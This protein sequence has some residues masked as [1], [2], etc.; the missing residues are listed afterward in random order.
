MTLQ[1]LEVGAPPATQIY[2]ANPGEFCLGRLSSRFLGNQSVWRSAA[3]LAHS[4]LR[5]D[6]TGCSQQFL[7][8][9][10]LF[11]PTLWPQV[12]GFPPW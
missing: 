2:A 12:L 10:S 5:E 6:V 7:F 11:S 8:Y 3:V 4:L 9:G 1:C